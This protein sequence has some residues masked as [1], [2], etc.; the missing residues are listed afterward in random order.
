ME[1]NPEYQHE[2]AR[3]VFQ[4]L[5]GWLWIGV[6]RIQRQLKSPMI[7]PLAKLDKFWHVFILHTRDYC[8][9]CETFFQHY[10][11]HEVK[12]EDLERSLTTEALADYLNDCYDFLG[13]GWVSR[14][15][16]RLLQ[17]DDE[18]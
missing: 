8:D 3:Q 6:H 9:F 13:E 12:P 16:S 18:D 15:F 17:M 2:E 7:E 11:H 4:D 14:N 5:L 10:L 1:E